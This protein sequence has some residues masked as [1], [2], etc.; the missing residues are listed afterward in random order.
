MQP[1]RLRL[2]NDVHAHGTLTASA[3]ADATAD[4]DDQ[5]TPSSPNQLPLNDT[6]SIAH[7]AALMTGRA[8]YS[9]SRTAVNAA[10]LAM[11]DRERQRERDEQEAREAA[12]LER[13]NREMTTV[14]GVRMTNEEAQDARQRVIDNVDFY[15]DRAIRQGKMTEADRE[16]FKRAIQRKKELED[17]RG[18]GTLTEAE[19]AEERRLDASSVGRVADDATA[20]AHVERTL[21]RDAKITVSTANAG[22][23][24]AGQDSS[25][26]DSV[27]QAYAS[28]PA[29]PAGRDAVQPAVA[30]QVKATGLDL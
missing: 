2:R 13:W 9:P 5:P 30:A 8:A 6:T 23:R 12:H 10:A 26:D 29:G 15:A 25:V 19:A 21:G 4:W 24:R 1:G 27:F 18:R 3:Y 14:G 22:L 20:E 17:K 11:Y 28:R 7:G 16:D